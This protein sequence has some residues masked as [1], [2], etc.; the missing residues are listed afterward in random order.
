LVAVTLLCTL[1]GEIASMKRFWLVLG[2]L[3]IAAL[4]VAEIYDFFVTHRGVA[5]FSSRPKR[6]LYVAGIAIAAGGGAF[7]Y[8]RLSPKGQRFVRLCTLAA[9]A[10]AAS[11][12]SAYMGLVAF[13][14]LFDPVLRVQGWP[15]LLVVVFFLG[16]A[17][18]LWFEFWHLLRR[19]A[20]RFL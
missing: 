6:L 5:Y 10:L 19:G 12:F 18:W 4:T 1:F 8:G 3:T 20:T 7:T 2:V 11:I 14:G 15:L 9:F 13:H 16:A 17:A